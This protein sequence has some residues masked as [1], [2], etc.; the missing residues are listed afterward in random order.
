MNKWLVLFCAFLV[1]VFACKD[2]AS[3]IDDLAAEC[4]ADNKEACKELAD[5]ALHNQNSIVCET[6][7][8]KLTNMSELAK[9]V[10]GS[11]SLGEAAMSQMASL[12]SMSKTDIFDKDWRVSLVFKFITAF[13]SVPAEHRERLKRKILPAIQI[14]SYPT[15]SSAVGDI[16]SIKTEWWSSDQPYLRVRSEK[17]KG[18]VFTC[19]IYVRKLSDPLTQTWHTNFPDEVSSYTDFIEADIKVSDLLK[20]PFAMVKDQSV[21]TDIARNNLDPYIRET[22]SENLVD[23]AVLAEIVFN[24]DNGNVRK[25]AVENVNFSNQEQLQ[26]VL[27]NDVYNEVR[28]AAIKKL[29]NRELLSDIAE[30]DEN[31]FVREAAVEKLTDRVLLA[32]IA[33]NDKEYSVRMAA[34]ANSNLTDQSLLTSIARK[35]D[36]SR[37]RQAA[38]EKLIDQ[39]VAQAVFEDIAKNDEDWIIRRK[40]VNSLTNQTILTDIAKNDKDPNVCYAAEGRLKELQKK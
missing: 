30:Q 39:R 8:Q 17:V 18:E 15:V 38:A 19:S 37:I 31:V 25:A 6:A 11:P 13:D 27:K 14:L 28:I 12:D 10:L 40:A 23:K 3:K 2:D 36:D 5:I 26:D 7:V 4:N 21:L 32:N 1:F 16:V 20:Q 9:I 24:D 33:K 35:D 29:T 34:V 22:A